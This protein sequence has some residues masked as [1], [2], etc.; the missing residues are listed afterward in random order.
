ML[1]AGGTGFLGNAVL[2]VLAGAG[3]DVT[4]TWVE[5]RE[6]RRVE[7]AFGDGV[8]LVQADLF[9]ADAVERAV[10]SVG[11]LGSVVN[12]VGGYHSAGRAH[13][14][15]LADYERMLELNLKPGFLLARA[16]I[17]RLLERGGGTYVGVS[18]RAAVRPFPGAAGYITA[19]AGVLAFVQALAADYRDAGIRANAVLPNAIDTPA[20]REQIPNA[21]FSKW[22]PPQEIARVV[23]FLIGDESSPI[24]GAAVPVYGRAA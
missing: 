22:V 19:K 20:N 11:D 10:A 24:T 12:L 18:A 7:E 16:A 5:E 4:S 9:D 6:R 15:D 17:P 2:D 8:A 13:E 14:W 1:V 23:R 21:D 3:Y